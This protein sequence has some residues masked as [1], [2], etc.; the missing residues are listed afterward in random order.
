VPKGQRC[1]YCKPTEAQ[2]L[3]RQPYRRAYT[4]PDYKRNRLARY[5]MTGGLCEACGIQLKG[6]LH[7]QGE[8]WQSDHIIE[9]RRFADPRQANVIDNL[10][11]YCTTRA[12]RKGCHAG[13]RKPQ[14]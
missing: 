6:E 12:G 11:V 3:Q 9:V 7:E 8:P 10:R 2:R 4:D 5:R 1:A 14:R 13:K